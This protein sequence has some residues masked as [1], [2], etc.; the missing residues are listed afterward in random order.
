[1]SYD[2]DECRKFYK[3]HTPAV[4]SLSFN[5]ENGDPGQ[6]S[7]QTKYLCEKCLKSALQAVNGNVINRRK[8]KP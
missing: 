6:L 3:N 4:E 2:C 1:M 5:V 7:V 8:L